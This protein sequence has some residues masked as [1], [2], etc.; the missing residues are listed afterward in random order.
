MIDAISDKQLKVHSLL[1]IRNGYIIA[2]TYFPPYR[3]H[4]QHQIYS[5]TKSF[6]SALVGIAIEQGFIDG[7]DDRVLDIFPQREFAHLDERKASLTLEHLLTMTTG[8]D[9]EEGLPTYQEMGR[10]EDWVRYVLDKPVTA[11]P[12]QQFNYCSGCSHVMSAIIQ[13]TSGM[14][15]LEFAE[16]H[17]F[18]PLGIY[19]VDWE[20]DSS[21]IPNGGWG[22]QMT[23]RDMA[24]LGYLYL[25]DGVWDG[26]QI[27][28][29]EWVRTSV[30]EAIQVD[31]DWVYGYQ[32][33][34]NPSSGAYAAIGLAGQL[35]YVIPELDTMVVF[36]AALADS[37][38]L[39]ELI[40]EYVVPAV[41]SAP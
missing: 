29:A 4:T 25:N 26:Q 37:S 7:I 36:T 5:V 1:I 20:P 23:P 13:E 10:T 28:P 19:N 8:L 31:E 21:G 6:I 35:V 18:A 33:W 24:K 2:E 17:L 16:K 34:V 3:R 32:W 9:W 22:L 30:T 39:Y 41:S 11:E 14:G 38:V 15:T 12:G 40:D 27:I